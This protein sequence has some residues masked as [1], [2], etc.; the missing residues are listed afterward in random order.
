MTSV[1]GH[2]PTCPIARETWCLWTGDKCDWCS[3]YR[4][5]REDERARIRAAVDALPGEAD[6]TAIEVWEDGAT[7]LRRHIDQGRTLDLID[8]AEHHDELE[9]ASLHEE[10]LA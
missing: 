10:G 3:A 1:R 2:E 7:R 9:F 5:G 4:K 6:C 8:L